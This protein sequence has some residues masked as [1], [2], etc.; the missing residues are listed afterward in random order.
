MKKLCQSLCTLYDFAEDN[1]F[2][3]ETF[4]DPVLVP[5]LSTNQG[6]H[7]SIILTNINNIIVSMDNAWYDISNPLKY[8]LKIYVSFKYFNIVYNSPY[9]GLINKYMENKA[10]RTA[11]IYGIYL[12]HFINYK[13]QF[14][15]NKMSDCLPAL[16]YRWNYINKKI[17]SNGFN[18]QNIELEEK[19][20][21]DYD[22]ENSNFSKFFQGNDFLDN[23]IDVYK[24]NFRIE[25]NND[26]NNFNLEKHNTV[27]KSCICLFNFIDSIHFSNTYEMCSENVYI[28]IY[29]KIVFGLTEYRLSFNQ[30]EIQILLQSINAFLFMFSINHLLIEDSFDHSCISKVVYFLENNHVFVGH[31]F[32]CEQ[33]YNTSSIQDVFNGNYLKEDYPKINILEHQFLFRYNLGDESKNYDTYP[34]LPL[35]YLTLN[36]DKETEKMSSD[37]EDEENENQSYENDFHI[38]IENEMNLLE[39]I[40]NIRHAEIQ[41]LIGIEDEF[42]I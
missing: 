1:L 25:N 33:K 38:D 32:E 5:L 37:E 20:G 23:N 14:K 12:G 19:Y 9:A 41:L 29:K 8:V 27:L 24:E 21:L 31:L 4:S 11:S 16:I 3:H 28:T 30:K 22:I 39:E 17:V 18:N 36:R 35:N 34:C 7:R 15:T 6:L 2:S 10:L 40:E 42:P 13:Q 26:N